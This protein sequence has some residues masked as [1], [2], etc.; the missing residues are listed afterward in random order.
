MQDILTSIKAYL[1]DRAVSPLT[2]AFFSA[3]VLWNYRFFLILFSSTPPS[4]EEKFLLIDHHFKNIHLKISN[5]EIFING[6]FFNGALIP[7]LLAISYIYIYPFLAKPVYEHS[8]K[9]QKE[10]MSIKQEQEN[11]RLLSV[12]ESREL[13]RRL[14]QMQS[15]HQE[16]VDHFNNQI[17]SLSLQLE[18]TYKTS[19]AEISQDYNEIIEEEEPPEG[20]EQYDKYIE[21][22]LD[23]RRTGTFRLNQLF[24]QDEWLKIPPT[25]R[26]I[27]GKRFRAQVEQGDYVDVTLRGKDAGNMQQYYKE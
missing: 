13:Y 17:S 23:M 14:A 22:L 11:Q 25:T 27:L 8:L 7:A 6:T 19:S 21:Q 9:K 24:G 3:W 12:E 5:Y 1:Y 4:P 10:L 18:N 20:L 26:K 16:E 15:K 2:G